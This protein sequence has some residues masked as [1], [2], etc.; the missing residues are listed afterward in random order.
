VSNVRPLQFIDFLPEVFH[1]ATGAGN[2]LK[3]FLNAFQ[4]AF[5]ELQAEL[6]GVPDLSSGGIPD[7]FAPDVTPPPQFVHR[8]QSGT[9]DFDF[10]N[11]LAGWIALPL[12]PDK[13]LAW[14]RAFFKAAIA[15]YP[16]RST[17]AGINGMLQ[18]WLSGDIVAPD[19]LH[20][21]VTDFS[22]RANGATSA[23]QLGATS[24]VGVDTILGL[25]PPFL[26][27]ANLVLDPSQA[28]LRTPAGIDVVQ[29][30]AR[31][32]L[33]FEKPAHTYYS[34][35]IAAGTMQLAAPGETVINGNPAAQIGVTTLLWRD[36]WVFVSE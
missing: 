3:T 18:A 30:T 9:A 5:E 32:M 16:Q 7:L 1:P 14:N 22:P 20:P 28:P 21:L 27:S 23:F 13:P 25:G 26:F 2:F 34:L 35:A 36:P 31:L 24:T 10:L 19:T 33:D 4:Q 17:L 6:E 8:A 11:Y 29:R 12:R 15:L